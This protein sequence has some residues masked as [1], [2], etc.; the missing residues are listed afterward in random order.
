M[1][2]LL[3]VGIFVLIVCALITFCGGLVVG[4]VVFFKYYT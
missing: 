2:A 1:A 4:T 3:D